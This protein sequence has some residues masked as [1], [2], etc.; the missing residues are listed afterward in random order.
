MIAEQL[1]R[2]F[3]IS[4]SIIFFAASVD[5]GQMPERANP[6]PPNLISEL[7]AKDAATRRAAATE[8][9]AIRARDAVRPL[10]NALADADSSVREAVAFALGQIVAVHAVEPLTRRLSDK[11]PE[12]RAAAAF[13]LGMIGD[14]K[15]IDKLSDLLSDDNPMMRS[16]GA[17]ALGLIQDEEA[18]DELIPLLDDDSFDVRYD[19]VWA[20]GQIAHPSADEHLRAA[21]VTFDSMRA[22]DEQREAFR[23]AVQYSLD[24]L[25]T[26][27]HARA[28]KSRPRRTTGVVELNRYDNSSRPLS[29]LQMA[30]PVAT[31]RALRAK[32]SGTVNVRVLVEASG[33]PVRAYV[34]RRIGYGLDQRAVETVMQYKFDPAMLTGL[35]QSTW[36]DLEVKF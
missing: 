16:A 5:A 31:E 33:R 36:V 7:K 1:K 17:F 15:S 24:S 19:A 27:Q 20:L 26:E 35:P 14:R 34:T 25:R 9:G 10:I 3:A 32:A 11:V 2:F 8:L 30:R 4:L 13:A 28:S 12:V 21:L 18:V 23:Q 29:I 6:T 22:S